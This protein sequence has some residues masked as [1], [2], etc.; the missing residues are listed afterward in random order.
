M[1]DK[2]VKVKIEVEILS[3]TQGAFPAGLILGVLRENKI[4]V[5]EL[6]IDGKDL[7]TILK[8]Q[9]GG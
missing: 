1:N 7:P 8:H 9:A 6:F 4:E 3:D 2:R 5:V